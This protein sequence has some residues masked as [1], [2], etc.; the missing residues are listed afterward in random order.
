MIRFLIGGL[1]LLSSTSEAA[2]TELKEYKCYVATSFSEQITLYRWPADKM[3]Y[4]MKRPPL[5]KIPKSGPGARP[6]IKEVFECVE[7]S[8][9]F[10]S[11]VANKLD[12]NLAR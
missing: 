7:S 4:N 6:L 5:K 11:A 12:A 3:H 9:S 2:D 1:V 10:K 8:S